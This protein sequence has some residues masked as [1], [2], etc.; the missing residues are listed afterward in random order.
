[1]ITFFPERIRHINKMLEMPEFHNELNYGFPENIVE[2][3][4]YK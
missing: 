2:N 1:M 3:N 4:L